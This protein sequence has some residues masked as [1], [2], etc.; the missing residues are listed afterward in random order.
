MNS[1]ETKAQ[2]VHDEGSATHVVRFAIWSRRAIFK[3]P[4]Q[5][6][7]VGEQPRTYIV[8]KPSIM[9]SILSLY[10]NH[11]ILYRFLVERFVYLYIYII[12]LQ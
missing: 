5:N 7:K 12:D 9:S 6:A 3:L 8:A 2:V 10:L 11:Y 4:H 1:T